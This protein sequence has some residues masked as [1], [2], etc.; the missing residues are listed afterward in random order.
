MIELIIGPMFSGKT[1]ELL[2]RLTRL[3]I[4]GNSVLLLRPSID[5]R[6]ILTHDCLDHGIEE[7]FVDKVGNYERFY[8]IDVVGIDEGQFFPGLADD[9][10]TLANMGKRIIISGLS[11]TSEAEPFPEIQACI[12]ISESI[13][14]LNAVCTQCGSQEGSFT[15]YKKGNKTEAVLVGEHE[16]TAL[17]RKCYYDLK[18]RA[19]GPSFQTS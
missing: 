7:M 19:T 4:G 13:T 12:P 1:T 18:N 8:D 11:A 6:G 15:F 14:K 9:I 16:Y 10:T 17:C 5:T 3:Q 2:R